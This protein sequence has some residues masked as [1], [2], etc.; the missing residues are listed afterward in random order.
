MAHLNQTSDIHVA[1]SPGADAQ[2]VLSVDALVAGGGIAGSTAAAALA[3]KGLNVLLCEAGLPS[4]KRLAG[5]LLHPPGA[6][7]LE[8]LGLLQ[9]L[10]DAG[11][12]P[13]YGFAVFQSSDAEPTV[14]SYSEVSG[15]RPVGIAL[16][17]G[18][19]TRTLLDSVGQR[20]NV[21]VWEGARVTG[22][23]FDGPVPRATVRRDGRT[24][25]VNARMVVSAE[26][27]T[28]KIRESA[29]IQTAEEPPFRMVGWKIPGGRL[30][31]PGY[32][33]VFVGGPAPILAYQVS[34]DEVRIMFELDIDSSAVVGSALLAALPEPFRSDVREAMVT[35]PRSTARFTGFRPSRFTAKNLAVVGDAGGCVH[36]LIASGMSFCAADAVRLA[37]S[38]GGVKTPVDVALDRYEKARRGPMRTRMALGP[39]M[40]E[41]L[42]DPS[43]EMALLRHGLFR[44]WETSR[45]GRARSMGL[46]TTRET[47]IS[48]MAAEYAKVCAHAM[49]GAATGV[50]PRSEIA[51]GIAGLVRRSSGYLK[52]AVFPV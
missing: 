17:H 21:S 15:G 37:E 24:Q 45:E 3:A 34:R 32:G 39:A 35:Q 7:H 36:P 33:H 22:V 46:L 14:L 48:V 26:G 41:A 6:G 47:R 20:D 29:Q 40:V 13:V 2:S 52:Q 19:L 44:Y 4:K 25:T 51:S 11:G 30:P 31:F 38:V 49:A 43:P 8:S 18:T 50:V 10:R 23:D 16:E 9:P 12:V 1:D 42:C 5:E 28:S 27:R